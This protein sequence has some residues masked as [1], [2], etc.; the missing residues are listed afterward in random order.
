MTVRFLV[1][2]PIL[3][4]A[5]VIMAMGMADPV[6]ADV[7]LL[8]E[9]CSISG[10][11]WLQGHNVSGSYSDTGPSPLS[12]AAC[13]D[14]NL[15]ARSTAGMFSLSAAASAAFEWETWQNAYSHGTATGEWIFDQAVQFDL[16]AC[17]FPLYFGDPVVVDLK[18]L[19]TGTQIFH[20]SGSAGGYPTQGYQWDHYQPMDQSFSLNEGDAYRFYASITATANNDTGWSGNLRATVTPVPAPGALILGATGTAIAGWLRRRRTL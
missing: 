20:Y 8:Y 3:V 5:V 19:T 7:H 4:F 2:A 13:R 6:S 18:D 12:G 15:S 16:Y 17:T 14:D 1:S 10:E 11:Y 9:Q